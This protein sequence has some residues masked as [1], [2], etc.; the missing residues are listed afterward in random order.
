MNLRKFIIFLIVLTTLVMTIACQDKTNPVQNKI[1]GTVTLSTIDDSDLVKAM[2]DTAYVIVDTRINDS[3]NGW[4]LDGK[5]GHIQGAVDFSYNWLNADDALLKETLMVK[6]I[7]VDKNIILYDTNL[8]HAMKVKTFLNKKGFDAVEIYDLNQW[9]DVLVQY[10]NY[11]L[12]LPAQIVKSIVDGH[13]PET[14][15]AA[16]KIKIVEASWGESKTSYDNGHVPTAFHINTDA[17]EPPPSWLLPSDDVLLDFL[18]NHGL[19]STDTVIVTGEEQMAAYRIA[20]ILRYL[21]VSDVRVLNG[22]TTA[23]TDAGYELETD[24]HEPVSVK[25]FG[26]DVPAN[27]ELIETISELQSSLTEPLFTLIDNRTWQEYIGDTSGYSY[28]DKMGRIPGAVFGYAGVDNAYSLSYFRNP[29]NTMRRPEEFIALW[30]SR[31]IDLNNRLAFM[32]G[33]GWRASEVFFYA[34]VYGIKSITL[35]SDGWIGWSKDNLPSET[36]E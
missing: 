1:D 21:G 30:E 34:D 18:L 3:F 20:L 29:D 9:T 32:C 11:Q 2:K 28:H 17:V 24:S 22:G 35:F 31:G 26:I 19:E 27:P 23:W 25:A 6:N 4:D 10:E 16:G 14:F 36:G 12:I 13:K 33:S 5:P 8:E 7:T 15:E